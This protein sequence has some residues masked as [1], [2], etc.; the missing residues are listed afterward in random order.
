VIL[1][2]RKKPFTPK[3]HFTLLRASTAFVA[4]FI[5]LFSLF[6]SQNDYIKMF[7]AITGAIYLGGAGSAIIGGLY[8]KRGATSGAWFALITSATFA[9]SGLILR[10]TWPDGIYPWL[11]ANHPGF[12]AGATHYIESIGTAIGSNWQVEPNEFP[13]NGQWMALFAIFLSITGYVTLSLFEWLVLRKPA[14]NLERMLNRGEYAIASD[15]VGDVVKPATGWRALLPTSEFTVGDKVIYY[16]KLL[17]TIIWFG[18]FLFGTLYN[19]WYDV[20]V[21]S[22]ITFWGWKVGI[23]LFIGVGTTIWFLIGGLID[24]RRLFHILATMQRDHTDSGM[25]MGDRVY[26]EAALE[27]GPGSD[28]SEKSDR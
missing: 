5:F 11:A 14:F 20:P 8:W 2:F 3:Q 27:S 23:T 18:I 26:D 28:A 9:I 19:L 16:A 15:R 1:P 4:L 22:W 17:W 7:F 24:I 25:V 10:Q 12:L 6:F 13:F 21:E